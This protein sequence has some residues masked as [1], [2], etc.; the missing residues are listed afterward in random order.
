[1]NTYIIIGAPGMGKSPIAQSFIKGNRCLVFDVNNEYGPRT[2]YAGQTPLAL[3]SNT[4][5]IRSRY[6]KGD[7]KEFMKLA[8]EK[9]NT[10]V[11]F[12][13][14]TA[15]FRGSMTMDVSALL[16]N[17]FHTGNSYVFLFHSINRVPPEIMEMCDYVVL[18]RTNDQEDT[19]FR[20]YKS[21]SQHFL[22]ALMF[23]QGEYRVI[24]ML[25]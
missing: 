8:K 24:K 11:V 9:R 14:A 17:K 21:I 20:K 18:L 23:K 6:I 1:M 2:K 5:E 10:V 16:I 4:N 12:E 7:V 15:F 13:E 19:V 3:S 25:Q 22:D